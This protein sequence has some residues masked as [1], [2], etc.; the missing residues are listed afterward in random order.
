[1]IPVDAEDG[2]LHVE[3]LVCVVCTAE[4]EEIVARVC[5]WG[6]Y[7]RPMHTQA[8]RVETYPLWK[9]FSW[10]LRIWNCTGPSPNAFWRRSVM[11]FCMHLVREGIID[12]RA[13]R[14]ERD[15]DG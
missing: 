7:N 15:D 12:R 8:R 3:V 6:Q 2:Q 4:A 5:V 11:V 10:S 1:M 13:K 9:F 14:R